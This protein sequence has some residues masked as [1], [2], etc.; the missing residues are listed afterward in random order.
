MSCATWINA[1]GVIPS[2]FALLEKGKYELGTGSAQGLITIASDSA[3]SAVIDWG[4]GPQV[5]ITRSYED[6]FDL[7]TLDAVGSK[8]AKL[9]GAP[10]IGLTNA[11]FTFT[12]GG[13]SPALIKAVSFTT[14]NTISIPSPPNLNSVKVTALDLNTGIFTGSFTLPDSLVPGN[15]RTAPL[16]GILLQG[17][18]EGRGYFNLPELPNP[19]TSAIKSGSVLL[20]APV[21]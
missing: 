14:A 12:D 4:K 11:Q 17:S 19:K 9:V 7:H 1:A 3:V 21:P 16:A 8:Y 15:T 20:A 2:H 6:G 5:G 10:I 13:L 18:H